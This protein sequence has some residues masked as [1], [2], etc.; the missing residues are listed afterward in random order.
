MAST[1]T[2]RGGIKTEYVFAFNR[3]KTPADEVHFTP[4]ELGLSGPAYVYDYFSG[5][6]KLLNDGAS[7][8]RAAGQG[9]QR[10]LRRRARRQKRHRL[11][12]RQE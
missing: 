11:P 5:A 8:Y 2:D 4:A 10:V 1:Y 12:R 3:P 7:F 6:G 9:C